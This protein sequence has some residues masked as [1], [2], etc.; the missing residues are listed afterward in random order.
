MREGLRRL[1][2]VLLL[3]CLLVGQHLA[4][5]E[6]APSIEEGRKHWSFQPIRRPAVPGGE[7]ANPIDALIAA[8]LETSGL[9][10][11]P[12][13]D[14]RALIRRVH[15]DLI[16]LPPPPA[17]VE[18]FVNDPDPA[19]YEHLVDRL[20]A[21]PHHGERWGRHWLDVVGFAESAMFIGDPIRPGYW[22]Y[23]D[24]VIRSL[25]EDKPFDR[26]LVEQLAGDE[27]FDWSAA[28]NLSPEQVDLL[29]ATGFLRTTPD[30]T[31]NQPIT[32]MDK[33]HA[34]QQ[35]AVEVSMRAVLGLTFQCA[36]CHDHKFDPIR[37]EDYY[38]LLAVFG[39]AYDPEAWLA[40]IWT[41][42]RPGPLRAIPILPRDERNAL[43]QDSR[44]WP[45]VKQDDEARRGAAKKRNALYQDAIWCLFDVTTRPSATRLLRR[46]NYETPGEEVAPGVP[47]VLEDAA[48]PVRFDR[49]PG[50]WTTGRRL[51]LARWLTDPKHPLTARV[52][53]NR[54]WQ[55]HFGTG[56]VSTPD[57]FGLRG[58]PP[59]NPELLDWLA[60]DLIDG[61]WRLRRLHRA[62]LL[63]AAYRQRTMN[64]KGNEPRPAL[65]PAYRPGPRRLEAG[66]IRD[67]MLDVAGS[68][69]RRL[70][71][72][73][74]PTVRLK[75]GRFEVKKDH[76]D[77]NRRS[78]YIS[79]RRTHVPTFLALFDEPIMD[80]NQPRRASSVIPQQALALLNGSFV[81]ECAAG[82]ARRVVE[83]GGATLEE[84]LRWA[85]ETAYGRPPSAEEADLFRDGLPPR[86]GGPE[87]PGDA[88]FWRIACHA[89]LAS[90]EFLH[91]D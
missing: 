55:Y 71:G 84:R 75:D 50:E 32:Q 37:Q 53:A 21:S 46:G 88:A 41:A 27:L 3:A 69:D 14:R 56:L 26:F 45:A 4:I 86:G 65:P 40:G 60:A 42:D 87:D 90:N 38:R 29:S 58:A 24:Y 19:A 91:V 28:E 77:R 2:P 76:P 25:N 30:A 49:P 73:S 11:A 48:R 34:A 23:R 70:L 68:L 47:A 20:L 17:E 33:R 72:P 59:V 51:A 54:I 9:G 22:R 18:S 83:E 64:E 81:L 1:Q 31:D 39:S 62:I 61:G 44:A 79:T 66:A 7:E 43:M 36:R 35:A 80:T 89:I 85:Y 8:R 12:A 5:A 63:S 13:A 6:G 52:I 74:I 57:D 16:G 78:I 82:F 67:A 15:F 10:I